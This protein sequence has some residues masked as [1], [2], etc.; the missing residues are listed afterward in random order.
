[1][2][3]VDE[4]LRID[5][6]PTG[7]R[8]LRAQSLRSRAAGVWAVQPWPQDWVLLLP[9]C[10]AVH[11]L[12]L[13]TALDVVFS[14]E[15]GHVL[16]VHDAVP[17]WRIRHHPAA[18]ATWEFAPGVAS[19][20]GLRRGVRLQAQRAGGATLIEFLLA[21]LLVVLPMVFVTLELARL[22]VTRH[23]LHHAVSDAAREA[24]FR[25]GD[26]MGLRRAI[27]YGLLPIHVPTDPGS[28]AAAG[29]NGA[30]P[31]VTAAVGFEALGRAAAEVFRPDLL[32][33]TLES[34]GGLAVSVGMGD[35][36]WGRAGGVWRLRVR[37]CREMI[38]P[39]SRRLIPQ[40]LR[41][42]RPSPFEQ[43]CLARQR[44]PVEATALVLR[45]AR[46][47]AVPAGALP[48]VPPGDPIGLP[49]PSPSPPPVQDP[50]PFPPSTPE[51]PGI[52]IDR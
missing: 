52:D 26:G 32:D 5:G 3:P 7:L 44:M 13:R 8:L 42:T 38:F 16:A 34:E 36:G 33:I 49:V 20:V 18:C 19:R 2:D 10:R 12:G 22:A 48:E 1:M 23:A 46:I 4:S 11:T 30:Q 21:T 27:A 31:P 50:A 15:S 14:D 25:I 45:G 43:L 6:R 17:P 35:I 37:Y 28:I 41:L 51:V 47:A 24:G 40:A 29:V 9:A 39:L